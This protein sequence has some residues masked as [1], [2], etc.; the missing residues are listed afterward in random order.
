[1]GKS[2]LGY[3]VRLK[4][5]KKACKQFFFLKKMNQKNFSPFARVGYRPASSSVEKAKEKVFLLLFVHKKKT[6]PT[7]CLSFFEPLAGF[8]RKAV[9][10]QKMLAFLKRRLRVRPKTHSFLTDSSEHQSD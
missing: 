7:T 9:F 1:M 8:V 4:S 2:F 10:F 5:L 3:S 6:L